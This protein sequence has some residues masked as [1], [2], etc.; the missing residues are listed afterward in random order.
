MMNKAVQNYY[1]ERG[2]NTEVVQAHGVKVPVW[3]RLRW[4]RIAAVVAVPVAATTIYMN[5]LGLPKLE[6]QVKWETVRVEKGDSLWSIIDARNSDVVDVR[7]LVHLTKEHNKMDSNIKPG[8]V[9]E[10]PV[11]TG[12]GK[13]RY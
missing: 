2:I 7:D 4:G 8:M 6:E 11:Y 9:I 3:K 10:V 13:Y 1:A 5:T 12:T